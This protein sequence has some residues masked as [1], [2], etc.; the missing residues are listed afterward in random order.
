MVSPLSEMAPVPV[1]KVPVELWASKLPAPLAKVMFLPAAR[2]VFWFRSISV[3]L[4]FPM[5]RATPVAVSKTGDKI[6]T[7]A[8]PVLLI[9]KLELACCKTFWFCM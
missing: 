5:P 1:W 8:L 4:V 7:S 2:T 9:Q 3:A 6:D